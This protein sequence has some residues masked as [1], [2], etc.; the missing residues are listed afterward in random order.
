[1]NKTLA[2]KYLSNIKNYKKKYLT[3]E[4][5]SKHIGIYPEIISSE[6]SY[7]EPMLAMDPSF[8]LKELLPQIEEYI[9]SIE[10]SKEKIKHFE[11][12]KES[13]NYN[14]VTDFV[15]KKMTVVGGLV[16]KSIILSDDDL[17]VLRKLVN[18]ELQSRKKK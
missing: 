14:G 13:K 2:K 6:L 18:E 11:A 7:F 10:S 5:L 4:Q 12:K 8:N 1:M 17:K 15:Y 9:A 16:D 3:S